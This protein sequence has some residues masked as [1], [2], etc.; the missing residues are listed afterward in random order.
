MAQDSLVRFSD[1][2]ITDAEEKRRDYIEKLRKNK[3]EVLK[4]K[5]EQMTREY[6]GYIQGECE[7][8]S[9]EAGLEASRHCNELQR[10]LILERNRMFDEIFSEVTENIKKYT[11]SA[12]YIERTKS[13]L[14]EAVKGFSHGRTV[15]IARECD[16]QELKSAADVEIEIADSGLLG[17]FS[18]RNDEMKLFLDCTLNT[19]INK[20]KELFFIESGLVIE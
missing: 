12:E 3:K 16:A 19:K 1:A 6:H 4:T 18:L 11:E 15:C 14:R 8:Y 7:K 20:Q 2:I 10:E 9:A 13:M 17:G 5:K